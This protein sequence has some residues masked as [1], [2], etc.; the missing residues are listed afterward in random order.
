MRS[1][2]LLAAKGRTYLAEDALIRHGTSSQAIFAGETSDGLKA[3]LAEMRED[4]RARTQGG[5][6]SSLR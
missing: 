4:A 6:L 3:L 2:P 5:A 1:V